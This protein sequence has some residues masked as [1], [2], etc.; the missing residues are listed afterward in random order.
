MPS[1]GV[2]EEAGRDG[3]S[4][5]MRALRQQAPG[6]GGMPGLEQGARL[7]LRPLRSAAQQ[8]RH[9]SLSPSINH[10]HRRSCS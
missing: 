6:R 5:S 3:S 8:A 10:S 7:N 1:E 9:P 4:V 2:S